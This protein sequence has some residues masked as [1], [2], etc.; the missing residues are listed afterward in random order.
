MPSTGAY[1]KVNSTPS[2][3]DYPYAHVCEYM[4]YLLSMSVVFTL[5]YILGL[6]IFVSCGSKE[7][8][9]GALKVVDVSIL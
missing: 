9:S 8:K 5:K 1:D 6:I 7:R 4:S 2:I 3:M